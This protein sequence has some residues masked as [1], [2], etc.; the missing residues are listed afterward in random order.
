MSLM[1]SINDF[2]TGGSNKNAQSDLAQALA[3]IQAVQTPTAQQLNLTPLAQYENTGNLTPAQMQA[4]LA[5]NN[6]L[7]NENLSAVPMSTMQQALSQEAGIA[8]ANGMT[9]QEQAAIAQAEQSANEATAGQ[10]G[11]IAQQ[12]AGEGVPQSLISAALQ[13]QTAGQTAQQDYQDALQAQGQAANEGLTALSN[14]GNLA[15][16]MY[17]QQAGQANTVAAAQNALNQF[18]AANTQQANVQN[19]A[20]QQSANTYNT[21]NAQTLAN[22]NV[23]GQ[24]Q[25]QEQNQVQAPQEA[26]SLALEK[27]AA[28]AGV[29][30]QQANQQTAVG[31]QNAGLVGSAIGATGS[32]LS[33]GP[34]VLGKAH[35]GE[36]EPRIP[37]IPFLQGGNVPGRAVVPGNSPRNDIIPAKLSPGEVVLPRTVAQNPGPQGTN[38]KRFL[39]EKVPNVAAKMSPHSSDL[40]SLLRAMSELRQQGVA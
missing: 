6:A 12:F 34:I 27:A 33:G 15:S 29:G 17:G 7:A 13:N 18:N 24:Q 20:N 10:R 35:G 19:L 11:A 1:G 3:A 40:A 38:I 30:E 2:L 28:Q 16:T 36:I 9:P 26:A 23:Q 21:E 39:Q 8:N 4:A 14:E 37:A 32:A 25:V 5:G 31:Q 22:Q